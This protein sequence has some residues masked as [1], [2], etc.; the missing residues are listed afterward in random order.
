MNLVI[1][2]MGN[3]EMLKTQKHLIQKYK[4]NITDNTKYDDGLN[5]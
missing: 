5:I 4:T 2:Y 3:T 1:S